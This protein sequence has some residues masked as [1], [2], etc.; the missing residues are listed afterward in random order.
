MCFVHNTQPVYFRVMTHFE[1]F[2][3]STFNLETEGIW[4]SISFGSFSSHK[5]LINVFIMSI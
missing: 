5:I 1:T 3:Q 4:E 2:S